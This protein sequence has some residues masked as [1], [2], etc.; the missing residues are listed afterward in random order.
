MTADETD[1]RVIAATRRWIEKAV[2]G[3]RL[4]PFAAAPFVRDQ[5]RY[6][7]SAQRSVDGLAQ[8]LEQELVRLHAADPQLC[9]TSLLI[10]PLVLA[11]FAAY[12]QFLGEA[13]AAIVTLRLRGKLQI[14][15]F[16]PDYQFAGSA[17]DDVENYSNRSP[18]PMLHLLRETS[19]ARAVSG[20]PAIGEIGERNMAT[21]RALGAR[22]CR[23]L[24]A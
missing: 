9:E 14:A 2:I 24:L 1:D 20:Y 23:D 8:E 18:Y 7:V 4:C 3:L 22:G 6:R 5:I 16:H 17:P 21:L 11:D 19:V 15:S 12:N 13:D 10:H